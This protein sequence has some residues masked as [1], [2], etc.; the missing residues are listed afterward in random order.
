MEIEKELNLEEGF[1]MM[2]QVFYDIKRLKGKMQKARPDLSKLRKGL[3]WD[4]DMDKIDWE[5]QKRAVI[6]RIFER[7]NDDEKM[8][9]TRFYGEAEN[10]SRP[11]A[12]R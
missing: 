3:F 11:Q 12:S 2:L 8:E 5:Q 7:G 1:L 9:I 4:I 10:L 6:Q